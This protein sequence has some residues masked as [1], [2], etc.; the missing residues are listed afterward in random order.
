MADDRG[1]TL[2]ELIVAI[3][4]L[5][6]IF[7][8]A[9]QIGYRFY[10]SQLLISERDSVANLLYRARSLA[11]NNYDQSDHGFYISGSSYTVFEGGS[12][13]SRNSALDETYARNGGIAESGPTEVVFSALTGDANASATMAFSNSIGYFNVSVNGEGRIDW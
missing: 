7:G 10:A 13:A 9:L 12:Y 1:F 6:V 2:I 11:M 5:S 4:I 8:Y 3:A